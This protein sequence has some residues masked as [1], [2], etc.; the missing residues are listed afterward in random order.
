MV[1]QLAVCYTESIAWYEPENIFKFVFES[2]VILISGYMKCFMVVNVLFL[3]LFNTKDH[4][5]NFGVN[6]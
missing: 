4:F 2:G 6:I 3:Q 1:K 5:N